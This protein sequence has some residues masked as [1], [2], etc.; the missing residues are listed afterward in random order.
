[1][2]SLRAFERSVW[3]LHRRRS[4]DDGDNLNAARLMGSHNIF[5][6]SNVMMSCSGDKCGASAGDRKMILLIMK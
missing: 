6:S 2:V 1:M 3:G 4:S 5:D